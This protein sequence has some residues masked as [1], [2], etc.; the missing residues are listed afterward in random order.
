[1]VQ[2]RY[3]GQ[4]V[5]YIGGYAL[6]AGLN[7]I[8][9]E[10]FYRFM[11]SKTFKYRV[12]SKILEVPADFPLEKPVKSSSQAEVEKPEEKLSVKEVLLMIE[13]SDDADYLQGLIDNDSRVKVVEEAKKKLKTLKQ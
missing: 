11:K 9:D 3:K 12:E 5:L 4:N 1:M 7:E 13:K 6:K 2:V 8:Q 10:D